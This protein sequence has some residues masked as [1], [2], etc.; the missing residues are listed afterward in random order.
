MMCASSHLHNRLGMY[1]LATANNQDQRVPEGKLAVGCL[2][3]IKLG[4]WLLNNES[5]VIWWIKLRRCKL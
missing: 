1:L 2:C 5:F 3:E 4:C